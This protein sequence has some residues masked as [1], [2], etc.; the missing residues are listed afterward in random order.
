MLAENVPIGWGGRCA[1][2][3]NELFCGVFHNIADVGSLMSIYIH[4]GSNN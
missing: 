4:F 1:M 3:G 2:H